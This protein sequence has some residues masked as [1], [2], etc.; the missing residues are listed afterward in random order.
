MT[1]KKTGKTGAHAKFVPAKAKTGK[2]G[3]QAKFVPGAA[4]DPAPS[5][6]QVAADAFAGGF[7]VKGALRPEHKDETQLKL[8][9]A[10]ATTGIAFGQL[11]AFALA[12]RAAGDAEPFAPEEAVTAKQKTTLAK[13]AAEKG[14]PAPFK[15]ILT[16]AAP[17]LE[18]RRDV[19]ALYGVLSGTMD[20]LNAVGSVMQM[21]DRQAAA[22]GR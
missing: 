12:V 1:T 6:S 15:A 2:T 16:A 20:K 17:K 21:A 7:Y 18:K 19:Y 14:L 11:N 8:G 4:A 13:L 10:L 5:I 9:F 22:A 3:T